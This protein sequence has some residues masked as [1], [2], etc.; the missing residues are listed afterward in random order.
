MSVLLRHPHG[1]EGFA[2]SWYMHT[3]SILPS[4]IV[5][6]VMG[7]RRTFCRAVRRPR[8]GATGRRLLGAS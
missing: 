4:W 3:R 2:R 6:T 7:R 8:Q 1:F 5:Q